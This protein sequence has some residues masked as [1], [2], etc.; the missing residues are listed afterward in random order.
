MSNEVSGTWST[1][2]QIPGT[3]LLNTGTDVDFNE[4]SCP[5]A[6]N[7][8]AVGDYTD[9]SNDLQAFVVDEKNGTWGSAIEAPGT[10]FLNSDGV[11]SAI[12]L[13]CSSAG[14]CSA[15]GTFADASAHLQAFSLNEVNGVWNSAVELPGITSLNAGTI[16]ALTS[17]TCASS[18][19]CSGVGI[20]TDASAHT[21]SFVD[22]EQGGI[23]G[24]AQETP[25]DATLNGGG[26]MLFNG[27]ACSSAGNCAAGGY[28]TDT[29]THLQAFTVQRGERRV[30][31]GRR[32][33]GHCDNELGRR[34]GR[35]QSVVHGLG[36]RASAV[37]NYTD[38]SGQQAFVVN[39]VGGT[40]GSIEEA[41]GSGSLNVGAVANLDSVS[42][43]S[44]GDCDAG[45]FYSDTANSTQAFIID[46]VNGTWGSV[47]ET[48]GTA[49]LN[50]EGNAEILSTSCSA[51]GDCT[52]GG[53]YRDSA[54]NYQAF[55][56][57]E[58]FTKA[59]EKIHVTVTQSTKEVKHVVSETGLKITATG[60]GSA[61]GSVAF[62]AGATKLCTA[63]ISGGAAKCSTSKHFKKGPIT[64]S[65][66]YAGTMFN[67]AASA[68]SRVS[69]K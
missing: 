66:K 33:S 32:A 30:G 52:D 14:N 19:N 16:S 28:Y 8:T 4:I 27:L 64:V 48:P 13:S 60:L 63:T 26:S 50:A 67:Q 58:T 44:P 37:G 43:T 65:A 39:E 47:Q 45:G 7:C 31:Y 34:V 3:A 23:W 46:E 42:C 59:T 29:A 41:P 40:W 51:Y 5:S 36:G 9:E 6:G 53:F 1:A 68:T 18:G 15:G 17:V 69:I 35:I 57:T 24:A 25:G 38:S 11:A 54:G 49:E 61:T 2:E 22:D 12:T 55:A 10:A 62:S 56:I 20:Y 21:Q